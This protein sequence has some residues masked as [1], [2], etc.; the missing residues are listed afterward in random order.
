M[1]RVQT[2]LYYAWYK[3]LQKPQPNE[4]F[5]EGHGYLGHVLF[6]M[7]YVDIDLR[8]WN[9]NSFFAPRGAGLFQSVSELGTGYTEKNRELILASFIYNTETARNLFF[10]FR[11]SPYYDLKNKLPE[12][13]IELYFR[14]NF[15]FVIKRF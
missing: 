13:S 14:Y 10:D 8:Y 5:S 7:K 1:N 3:D 15:E 4:I 11:F 2:E 12:Y 9:G 6:D